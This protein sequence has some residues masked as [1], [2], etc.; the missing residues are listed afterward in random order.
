MLS[1]YSFFLNCQTLAESSPKVK[2]GWFL[3]VFPPE[4]NNLVGG[5]RGDKGDKSGRKHQH[6]FQ[7]TDYTC[8]TGFLNQVNFSEKYSKSDNTCFTS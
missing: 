4:Q 6:A 5:G 1:N 7:Q 8:Q 3:F 2:L